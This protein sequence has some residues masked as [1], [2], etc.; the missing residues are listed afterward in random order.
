LCPASFKIG[1]TA[2]SA[3]KL[4][5]PS[6]SQSKTTQTHDESAASRQPR[7]ARRLDRTTGRTPG[8]DSRHEPTRW[9]IELVDGALIEVWADGYQREGEHH[10]FTALID[11]DDGE[12]LP[13]DA[14]IMGETPSDPHRF[15][16]AVARI[17]RAAVLVPDGN[18]ELACHSRV[19]LRFGVDA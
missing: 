9:T 16:L 18:E 7:A 15:I 4:C 3:T 5:Q 13:D 14:M 1:G 2:G 19:T 8:C 11:L 6:A 10:T 12:A 17:P